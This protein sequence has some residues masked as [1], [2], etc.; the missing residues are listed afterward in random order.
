VLVSVGGDI[1]IAGPAPDRGWPVLVTEDHAAPLGGHGQVVWLTGG[2][3]ATSSITVRRWRRGSAELHHIV[4]PATGLPA[5]GPWRTASVGAA[6]CVDANTAATAAI[7][8]GDRAAAWLAERRLPAR[9][10]G[11]E[12]RVVTVAGWPE[13]VQEASR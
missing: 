3:L 8:L 9:L 5:E 10:V 7:V 4:D 2:G 11:R 12:G 13:P 6:T 1:A